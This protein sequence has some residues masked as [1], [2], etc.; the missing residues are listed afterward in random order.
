M[1]GETRFDGETT[2][3]G[4]AT[5]D[6]PVALDGEATHEPPTPSTSAV[7]ARGVRRRWWRQHPV[8]AGALL[9]ALGVGSARA[10]ITSADFTDEVKITASVAAG[11]LDIVVN[12]QQCNPSACNVPLSLPAGGLKPGD[13]VSTVLQVQNTGS[14]AALLNTKMT[15]LP[16]AGSLGA[17]LDATFTA[18][19]SGS[20]VTVGS[21][22]ANGATLSAFTV[23][24]GQTVPLTVDLSLPSSTDNSWQGHS[25][26]LTVTLTAGQA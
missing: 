7:R 15:G 13:H 24:A 11:T 25:D 12:G 2:I 9:V 22:K 10:V 20:P 21:G 8:V 4:E 3:G 17:Q 5:Q 23:P 6:A 1:N 19:P 18:S 26:T 14:L 16:A